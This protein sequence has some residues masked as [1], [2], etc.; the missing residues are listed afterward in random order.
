LSGAGTLHGGPGNDRLQATANPPGVVDYEDGGPGDDGIRLNSRGITIDCTGGGND[1]V[2]DLVDPTEVKLIGCGPPPKVSIAVSRVKLGGLLHGKL[3]VT[4]ACDRPCDLEWAIQGANRKTKR[5][6]PRACA[7]ILQHSF[8]RESDLAAMTYAPAGPQVFPVTRL[9]TGL[10]R[11]KGVKSFKFNVVVLAQ[12]NL[13]V[14]ARAHK[15][16]TVKR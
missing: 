8:A 2:G 6:I 5:S 7:C 11:T 4:I 12:S 16:F 13:G 1:S 3:V 14:T 9:G 10:T 15:L